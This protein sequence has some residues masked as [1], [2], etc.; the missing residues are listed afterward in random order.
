MAKNSFRTRNNPPPRVRAK[1]EG[2][3]LTKQSFEKTANINN[4]MGNAIKTGMPPMT[5]LFNP[6]NPRR[7]YFGEMRAESLHEMLNKVMDV[8]NLFRALPSRIRSR[9]KDAYQL[10]RWLEDPRNENE[11][12]RLGL[13]SNPDKLDEMLAAEEKADQEAREAGETASRMVRADPEA[14]PRLSAGRKPPPDPTGGHQ[15][16]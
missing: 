2:P 13:L 9:F 12:I 6:T 16:A 5:G 3:S 15:S 14:N 8:Q 4:I 10:L 7:A 11:A 1:V